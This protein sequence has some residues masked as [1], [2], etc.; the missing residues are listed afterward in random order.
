MLKISF[1]GSIEDV[2]KLGGLIPEF[3]PMHSFSE[4]EHRFKNSRFLILIAYWNQ[5]MAGFKVGYD[6]YKDGSF[7]SWLGAVLPEFR[8]NKIAQ[9]LL[10]EQ[11]KWCRDNGFNRIIVK[12]RNKF[13]AMLQ[14]LIKKNYQIS[15][16][17]NGSELL[18]NRVILEKQL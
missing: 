18:E 7:Y 2:I 4:F 3:V 14:F 15:A 1:A 9:K 16:C 11:E 12:T 5:E 8:R 13:P 6:R 17:I 10:E